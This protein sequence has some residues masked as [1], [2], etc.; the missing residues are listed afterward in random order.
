[1]NPNK[2]YSGKV[3]KI[4][5]YGS[6]IRLEE[7][8]LEVLA[9]EVLE[10]HQNVKVKFL[11]NGKSIP[12]VQIASDSKNFEDTYSKMA[13]QYM[14][15]KRMNPFGGLG[16]NEQGVQHALNPTF[17]YGDR[18]GLGSSG[19][20]SQPTWN[21]YERFVPTQRLQHNTDQTCGSNAFLS[22]SEAVVGY[23]TDVAVTITDE[24]AGNTAG[25]DADTE[26]VDPLTS[27]IESISAFTAALPDRPL[28]APT[29]A[30][31]QTARTPMF[32]IAAVP[33]LTAARLSTVPDLAVSARPSHVALQMDAIQNEILNVERSNTKTRELVSHLTSQI[34]EL[35]HFQRWLGSIERYIR[36]CAHEE[37]FLVKF[38]DCPG[39]E[40]SRG[41]RSCYLEK[42]GKSQ[43]T[44]FCFPCCWK[45]YPVV[46]GLCS[47]CF[48]TH[49]KQE[50]EEY[51]NPKKTNN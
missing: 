14:S 11:R 21:F 4:K 1:M 20:S 41:D 15:K 19:A 44:T 24:V 2:I 47:A 16:K 50:A 5:E 33:S 30:P 8:D 35:E 34:N 27:T 6:Y 38:S 9:N 18:Q 12:I 31:A 25:F 49:T 46:R 37:H 23:N 22:H 43:P 48:D 36:R 42:H 28:V 40:K 10:E 45:Y 29:A 7:P 13:I 17:G 32:P 51:L 26:R 39:Y 3:Y